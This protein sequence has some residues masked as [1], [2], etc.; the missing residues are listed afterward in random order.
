[1][2]KLKDILLEAYAWER[3][4]GKGLPT[5]A[6]VEA[7]HRKNLSEEDDLTNQSLTALSTVCQKCKSDLQTAFD[8]TTI[9]NDEKDEARNTMRDYSM[10]LMTAICDYIEDIRLVHE[11]NPEASMNLVV[12]DKAQ[13]ILVDKSLSQ[14]IF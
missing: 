2:K 13:E 6:E 3:K 7:Q 10:V 1:M 9:V 14:M 12:I 5:L 8:Q 11:Q 4:S